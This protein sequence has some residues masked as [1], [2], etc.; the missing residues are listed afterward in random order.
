MSNRRVRIYQ[1]GI[2][3]EPSTI[4]GFSLSAGIPEAALN[5]FCAET[6]HNGRYLHPTTLPRS[7]GEAHERPT[8]RERRRNQRDKRVL[9]SL[10]GCSWGYYEVVPPMEDDMLRQL[11]EV[12]SQ[13][14]KCGNDEGLLIDNR[15]TPS[16]FQ[17]YDRRG[18]VI[19]RWQ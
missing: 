9:R 18:K 12:C 17:P 15:D 3:G 19:A 2:E 7:D 10:G 13:H 16:P 6:G 5:E 4:I 11:A 1:G 14:I 8:W